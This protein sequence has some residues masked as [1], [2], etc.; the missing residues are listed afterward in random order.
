MAFICFALPNNHADVDFN[1]VLIRSVFVKW[2]CCNVMC[3]D[4]VVF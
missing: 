2:H 1:S 3:S 4:H